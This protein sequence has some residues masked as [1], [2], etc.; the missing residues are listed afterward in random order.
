MLL[1]TREYASLANESERSVRRKC[2]LGY[3]P[4]VRVGGGAWLIEAEA[5]ARTGREVL[6]QKGRTA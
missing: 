1:S 5:I 3:L 4:A 6:R 2:E